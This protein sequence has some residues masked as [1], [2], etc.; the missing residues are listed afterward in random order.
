MEMDDGIHFPANAL[1]LSDGDVYR[2]IMHNIRRPSHPR[3]RESTRGRAPE[4]YTGG[5]G[6]YLIAGGH[7]FS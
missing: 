1:R 4:R 2:V 7:N 6:V 3:G 5:V